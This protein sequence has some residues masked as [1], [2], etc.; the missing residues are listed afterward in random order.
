M[1]LLFVCFA[2]F[3]VGLETRASSVFKGSLIASSISLRLCMIVYYECHPMVRVFVRS[4]LM[5]IALSTSFHDLVCRRACRN[6]LIWQR[7]IQQRRMRPVLDDKD[8][9]GLVHSGNGKT[10]TLVIGEVQRIAYEDKRLSSMHL[11]TDAEIGAVYHESCSS[12]W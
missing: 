6:F 2:G 11:R 4:V 10:A 3:A 5:I 12:A 1:P 9:D 8:T 7:A